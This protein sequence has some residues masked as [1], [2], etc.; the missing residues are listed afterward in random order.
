MIDSR[1][2]N[3]TGPY[4]AEHLASFVQGEL[5]NISPSKLLIGVAPL[6]LANENELTFYHN[7]K[8]LSHLQSAKAGL[9]I[10]SSNHRDQAPSHL[11]VLLHSHPYRA[12]GKIAALFYQP[13]ASQE[14]GINPSAIIAPTAKIGKNCSIGAFCAIG[15]HVEIGDNCVLEAH[16]V[17]H[18]NVQIGNNCYFGSHCVISH[19]LIGNDVYIKCGTK[20]GQ[21]GF[22]FDMS[23]EG[24]FPIPQ[25]GR[26]I[27]EDD[28]EVGANTTIDRGASGDT[29]LRKMVRIDNLCQIAHNVELGERTVIVSQTGISG[30][31]KFGKGV[32]AGGQTGFAGHLKIGDHARIAAQSGVMNNVEAGA[33][34]MGYPAINQRD[35]F[36][37][38]IYLGRLSQ[39]PTNK[40]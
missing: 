18:N 9:C 3:N 6:H 36:K 28:V 31:T 5:V 40:N 2:Y 15:D 39:L 13:K 27:I 29:I 8:H 30:S 37:R 26:V 14:T 33:T 12:Y 34:I 21:K 32:I 1:F 35:F 20:I 10:L 24:F 38:H 16:T 25:L 22:G 17:I 11:G 7:P 4:T 23:P 19:A